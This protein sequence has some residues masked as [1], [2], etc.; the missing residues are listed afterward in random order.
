MHKF[1]VCKIAFMREGTKEFVKES[2]TQCK[3][4]CATE[5]AGESVQERAFRSVYTC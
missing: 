3:R 2:I 1:S 5:S 4:V